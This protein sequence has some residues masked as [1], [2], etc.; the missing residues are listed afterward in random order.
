MCAI[1]RILPS[2]YLD[3]FALGLV[4][5]QDSDPRRRDAEMLCQFSDQFC[6]GFSSLGF[7][8]YANKN[9]G[10]VGFDEVFMESDFYFVSQGLL[11]P[12]ELLLGISNQQG[13]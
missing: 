10:S 3:D 11:R 6:V 9:A 13:S 1:R 7:A 2:S 8:G 5:R 4:A 12:L